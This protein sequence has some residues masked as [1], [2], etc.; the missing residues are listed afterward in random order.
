[1]VSRPTCRLSMKKFTGYEPLQKGA[2]ITKR[3]C[4][5]TPGS[6]EPTHAEPRL[7][8]RGERHRLARGALS[9]PALHADRIPRPLGR[10]V[11]VAHSR[12]HRHRRRASRARDPV[13]ARPRPDESREADPRGVDVLAELPLSRRAPSHA[14]PDGGLMERAGCIQ[15]IYLELEDRIVV[16]IMVPCALDDYHFG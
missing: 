10:A 11:P 6:V 9:H 1:M 13:R 2:S 16:T 7:L 14:R 5:L 3:T 8:R 4:A 15:M 12:R